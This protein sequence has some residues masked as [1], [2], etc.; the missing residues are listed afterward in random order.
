MTGVAS[1]IRKG[2]LRV[3]L[4]IDAPQ[5]SDIPLIH[6]LPG[7]VEIELEQISPASL[8]L[9]VAGRRAAGDAAQGAQ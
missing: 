1:E 6:G 3:E 9:R 8:V 5:A 7:D 2:L 4:A